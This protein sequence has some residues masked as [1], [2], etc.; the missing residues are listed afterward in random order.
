MNLY[1]HQESAPTREI[2]ILCEELGLSYQMVPVKQDRSSPYLPELL[3]PACRVPMI[4][5]QG[6]I[7]SETHAIQRYLTTKCASPWYPSDRTHRA[8]VDQWMDWQ[9]LRLA[10]QC[11]LI[12]YHRVFANTGPSA[13]ALVGVAEGILHKILPELEDRLKNERFITGNTPT[14]ADIGVA[15][16]LDYLV[17]AAVDLSHYPAI[18]NWWHAFGNRPSWSR[19]A[20]RF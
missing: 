15:C 2:R 17:R 5:D 18:R 7:L 16:Y 3:D 4:D 13:E 20:A 10:P 1:G 19:T 14:L 9:A 12:A 6:F 11:A 8:L